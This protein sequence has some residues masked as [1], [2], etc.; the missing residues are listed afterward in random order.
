MTTKKPDPHSLGGKARAASLSSK[1][2][3]DIARVAARARWKDN[4][5][6]KRAVALL[7]PLCDDAWPAW[8][9]HE[10]NESINSIEI[11][12]KGDEDVE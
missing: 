8:K 11:L 9:I 5:P 3:S 7:R 2:R 4:P 6:W 12:L 10:F 1:E